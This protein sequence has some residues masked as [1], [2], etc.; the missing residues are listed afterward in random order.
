MRGPAI[1]TDRRV[2]SRPSRVA[3]GCASQDALR[4]D[5]PRPRHDCHGENCAA[6]PGPS[7]LSCANGRGSPCDRLAKVSSGRPCCFIATE[8]L[9]SPPTPHHIPGTSTGGIELDTVRTRRRRSGG[10][11]SMLPFTAS[12]SPQD[13]EPGVHVP[14]PTPGGMLRFGVTT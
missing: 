2:P 3:H 7:T 12:E 14:V 4:A 6:G 13:R 11:A 1:N 8:S 9:Q 5:D 10:T